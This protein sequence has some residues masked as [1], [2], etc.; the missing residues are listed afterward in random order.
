MSHFAL[1]LL[2]VLSNPDDYKGTNGFE[3]PAK[4]RKRSHSHTTTRRR[5]TMEQEAFDAKCR[6]IAKEEILKTLRLAAEIEA[7]AIE[8]ERGQL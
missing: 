1:L 5:H 7:E 4:K 8:S 6:A 2:P 3:A